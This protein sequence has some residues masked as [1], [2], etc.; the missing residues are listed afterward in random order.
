MKPDVPVEL[1]L[2]DQL[3]KVVWKSEL[4]EGY[5]GQFDFGDLPPNMYFLKIKSEQYIGVKKIL[6][7]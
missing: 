4:I 1:S 2:S 5:S 7:E 3:G 6:V